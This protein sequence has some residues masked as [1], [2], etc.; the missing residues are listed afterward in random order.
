MYFIYMMLL[1]Q[2]GQDNTHGFFPIH[3][4]LTA[5]FWWY[6]GKDGWLKFIQW[7]SLQ[8]RNLSL[9]E[10][11]IHYLLCH[12]ETTSCNS[13]NIMKMLVRCLVL[14]NMVFHI[15]GCM[16]FEELSFS[17]IV[18]FI[19][20]SFRRNLSESTDRIFAFFCT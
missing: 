9:L 20:L 4:N 8:N 16:Q 13:V 2:G 14:Q 1:L 18:I 7:A 12:M 3:F 10:L 6:L 15:F 17:Y 19:C 11:C 5:A